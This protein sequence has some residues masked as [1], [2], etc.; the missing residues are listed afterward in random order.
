LRSI[1]PGEW[2]MTSRVLQPIR[3]GGARL[4][5]VMCGVLCGLLAL[6][7]CAAFPGKQLPSYADE[8]VALGDPKPS[9]GYD[10]KSFILGWENASAARAFQER[11]NDV[12]GRSHAFSTFAPGV[13]PEKH[14]LSLTLRK[15]GRP[16]L[17]NLSMAVSVLTALVIP[18]YVKT[19]YVLLADVKE[20]GQVIKHYEYRDDR[21]IWTELFLI[22][23]TPTHWPAT[24][25]TEVVDNM[26]RN[27]LHDLAKDKTLG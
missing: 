5:I 27:L 18:A 16:V 15:E 10:A 21:T 17:A 4:V 6:S 7:A 14:H 20:G 13:G 19:E 26:L 1:E 12:F 23:L 8:P 22:V 3:T 11:I 25:E 9:I 24:V 2:R